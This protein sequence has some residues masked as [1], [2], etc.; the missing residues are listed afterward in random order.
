MTHPEE[1]LAEYV[2]GSLEQ[3]ERA[4]VEAHL[5]GCEQCRDE[6]SGARHARQAL[7]ALPE[8]ELPE[9]FRADRRARRVRAAPGRHDRLRRTLVG[10]GAAAASIAA[11]V[12]VA[13]L[14]GNGGGNSSSPSAASGAG[15]HVSASTAYDRARVDQLAATLATNATKEDQTTFGTAN[16]GNGGAQTRTPVSRPAGLE[17]DASVPPKPSVLCIRDTGNLPPSAHPLQ[18]ISRATFNGTPASIRA[19]RV[20]HSIRVVVTSRSGCSVLYTTSRPFR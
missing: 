20:G 14:I 19:Y 1:L 7:V 11:I 18:T 5:A 17:P 9:G 4:A 13:V 8:V 10:V 16:T 2:D 6:V 3:D 12:G 15:G